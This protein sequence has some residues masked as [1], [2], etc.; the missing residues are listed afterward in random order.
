MDYISNPTPLVPI[1]KQF[2]KTLA[3]LY[4]LMLDGNFWLL[5]I[6]PLNYLTRKTLSYLKSKRY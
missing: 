6:I 1:E 3:P 5:K 2:S 4:G